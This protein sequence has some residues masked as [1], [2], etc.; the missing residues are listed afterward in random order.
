[1]EGIS[2]GKWEVIDVDDEESS[3]IMRPPPEDGG[4]IICLCPDAEV[5][6]TRWKVNS[7][8]IVEA[9]NVAQECGLMPRELL[10][11]RDRV[12]RSCR[13][14]KKIINGILTDVTISMGTM[15]ELTK[16][17][18]ELKDALNKRGNDEKT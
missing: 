9:G 17:R 2:K 4:D 15:S 10:E 18:M 7:Q 5:S 11:E 1:M 14:V 8:L 12:L 3:I 13:R 6:K 16:A